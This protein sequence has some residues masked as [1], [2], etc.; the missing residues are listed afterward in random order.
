MV[1][2]LR[3][4]HCHVTLKCQLQTFPKK[5]IVCS[6]FYLKMEQRGAF[7][8]SFLFRIWNV[9]CLFLSERHCDLNG[10]GM[11]GRLHFTRGRRPRVAGCV[12]RLRRP[13]TPLTSHQ[14]FYHHRGRAREPR[15]AT[16]SLRYVLRC[17]DGRQ[18]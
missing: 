17:I 6:D 5:H 18:V 16:S 11:L 7:F 8:F 13:R 12:D 15:P 2:P 10:P 14:I 4:Q 3:T 9:H 1:L